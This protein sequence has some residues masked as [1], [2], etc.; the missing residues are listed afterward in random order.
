MTL[1][2]WL[3]G[4]AGVAVIVFSIPPMTG[5]VISR[6]VEPFL[7]GLEGRPSRLVAFPRTSSPE[8][9][10]RRLGKAGLLGHQKLRTRLEAAGR[11]TDEAAF[12]VEQFAW[13]GLGAA[14]VLV[15]GGAAA[16]SGVTPFS[17]G[18]IAG[19]VVAGFGAALARDWF[20]SHQIRNRKAEILQQLPTAIDHMTLALMAGEAISGAIARVGH[21]SGP[22]C[23]E[24][25]RLDGEIRS[26]WTTVEALEALRGRVDEP[27]IARFV[28][29]VCTAIER[30]TSLT[31]VLR[32]Q[33]DDVRE[34]RRRTLLELG[35]RR[36][37]V[38]LLPVVFLIMPVIV[39][40]AL[41][42]GL[43][44]LDLLVP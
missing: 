21:G 22:L 33:A 11:V 40:F 44:S 38:M 13:G 25:T 35:G 37:V 28:D 12:R 8:W 7:D 43:V 1:F 10:L 23:D 14:A 18:L 27:P 30:G 24:F 31:D 9:V 5:G 39:L 2:L 17:P 32:A 16:V 19:S 20:L 6:R 34:L 36:E 26:G 3:L 29:A 42:P 4:V 41:W 15:A